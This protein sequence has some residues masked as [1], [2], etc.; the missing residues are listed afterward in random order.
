MNSKVKP[1]ETEA[2][3]S[4]SE[5]EPSCPFE[6]S[7]DNPSS[8]TQ[9]LSVGKHTMTYKYTVRATQQGTL[10]DMTCDVNIIV[11]GMIFSGF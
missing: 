4:W 3:V 8:P 7:P 11:K 10:F 5:P 6:P 9:Q 1:G 2:V